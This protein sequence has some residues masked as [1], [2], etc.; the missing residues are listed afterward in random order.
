MRQ[1]QIDFDFKG[2]NML[3]IT[4]YFAMI[5]SET[6]LSDV[7]FELEDRHRGQ[8][9]RIK[10]D[11]TTQLAGNEDNDKQSSSS[12]PLST[13][14][15]CHSNVFLKSIR[16]SAKVPASCSEQQFRSATM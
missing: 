8:K 12:A 16:I 2:K 13:K 9:Q 1:H 5:Q 7:H 6:G 15:S 3:F 11:A 14:V 10:E 4:D